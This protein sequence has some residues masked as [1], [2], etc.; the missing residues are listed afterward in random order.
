MGAAITGAIIDSAKLP[1]VAFSRIAGR[2]DGG[3]TIY[4]PPLYRICSDD[5]KMRSQTKT[6][7]T[8]SWLEL[9]ATPHYDYRV[10]TP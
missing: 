3:E 1:K 5:C 8:E 7:P 6:E 2:T 9:R 4:K 10:L